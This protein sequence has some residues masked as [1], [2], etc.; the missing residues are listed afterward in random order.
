[1]VR[2]TPDFDSVV[3]VSSD[4]LFLVWKNSQN[5]QMKAAAGQLATLL[6]QNILFSGLGD[7]SVAGAANGDYVRFDVSSGKWVADVGLSVNVSAIFQGLSVQDERITSL[8]NQVS[9]LNIIVTDASARITSVDNRATSIQSGVVSVNARVTSVQNGLTSVDAR[10]TSVFNDLSG[11]ITSV[12]ARV[13]SVHN[14][15]TSVYNYTS[16][17]VSILNSRITS[18]QNNIS[19]NLV[20]LSDVSLATSIGADNYA[21]IWDDTKQQFV[22]A[23]VGGGGSASVAPLSVAVSSFVGDNVL[24][25]I[26]VENNID[27]KNKGFLFLN[28]VYQ[29]KKTYSVSGNQIILTSAL[30][31]TVSAEWVY[32]GGGGTV[33]GGS[34][35]TTAQFNALVST[36]AVNSAALTSLDGRITSVDLRATSVNNLVSNLSFDFFSGMIP[37]VSI[38]RY[39]V[40]RRASRRYLLRSVY[41]ATS[42]GQCTYSLRRNGTNLTGFTSINASV[43]T[44]VVTSGTLA[45]IE[46]GDRLDFN[47]TTNTSAVDL[48]FNIG[49]FKI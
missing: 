46:V 26:T 45:T 27:D 37:V 36:V 18:V 40:D 8:S 1:M 31:S 47:I 25:T 38:Q 24:T 7:V 2:R 21:V 22:L 16:N 35:V 43:N 10:V 41:T 29:N 15:I 12:D 17:Q 6:N 11:D 9:T 19:L 20:S 28:G 13:T 49:I 33:G 23:S 3:E 48:S 4:D 30:P 42:L 39:D 14:D 5:R 32:L 44:S 34:A